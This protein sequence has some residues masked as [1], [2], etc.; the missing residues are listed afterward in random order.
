M[1]IKSDK[2][3]QHVKAK[4][5]VYSVTINGVVRLAFRP[6]NESSKSYMNMDASA[7]QESLRPLW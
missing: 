7:G 4:M 1:R 2:M 6:I 5:E 3:S